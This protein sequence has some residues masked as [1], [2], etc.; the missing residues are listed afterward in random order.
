MKNSPIKHTAAL[1][2]ALLLTSIAFA[3]KEPAFDKGD[4]TISIAV[5]LGGSY[6]NNDVHSNAYSVSYVSLPAFVVTYDHGTFSEVG[7]GT[8]GI[9]GMVGYRYTF[10][11]DYGDYDANWTD[12]VV[13][14]RGTYHLTLLKE[15]NNQFDPYGGVMAGMRFQSYKNTLY[16]EFEESYD[17]S[18]IYPAF[19]LFVGAKYNFTKGFG[20]FAEIGYDICILRVGLNFNF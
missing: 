7:P 16:D 1:F 4:N 2:T 3:Q 14:A 20:A 15:K 18:R 13:G 12:L 11:N 8:I 10:I 17:Q 9:G 19:G 5:G 6:H